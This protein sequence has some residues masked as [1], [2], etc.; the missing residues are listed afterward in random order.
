MRKPKGNRSKSSGTELLQINSTIEQFHVAEQNH[1]SMN[2]TDLNSHCLEHIFKYLN[3]NDL[4]NLAIASSTFEEAAVWCYKRA[5]DRIGTTITSFG[6]NYTFDLNVIQ[7][8]SHLI[9]DIS[10]NASD[11]FDNR[12]LDLIVKHFGGHL[13]SLSVRI[14]HISRL[15]KNKKIWAK[16]VNEIHINFPNL[17]CLRYDGNKKSFR[18]LKRIVRSYPCLEQLSVYLYGFSIESF[19]DII[20]LNPQLMYL[21]INYNNVKVMPD[22]IKFVAHHLVNLNYLSL[23]NGDSSKASFY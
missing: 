15:S 20:R 22:L 3:K 21:T 14:D 8:F 7:H 17:Q 18:N 2:I 4:V 5:T 10:I 19:K 16:F 6:K 11:D 1:E 23:N 12:L 13:T 9:N